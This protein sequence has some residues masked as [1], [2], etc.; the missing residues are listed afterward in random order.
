MLQEAKIAEYLDH[1]SITHYVGLFMKE[2]DLHDEL[3]DFYLVGDYVNGGLAKD[4]FEKNR[5]PEVG[6]KLVSTYMSSSSTSV[7]SV[8]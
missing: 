1:P 4:Y 3:A 2:I 5:T 6:E 7:C 8:N